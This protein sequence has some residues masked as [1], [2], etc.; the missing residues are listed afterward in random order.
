L[1]ITHLSDGEFLADTL[2]D[3]VG[4]VRSHRNSTCPQ[5]AGSGSSLHRQRALSSR[6]Y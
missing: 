3:A 1:V 6:K 5:T 2:P 4:P